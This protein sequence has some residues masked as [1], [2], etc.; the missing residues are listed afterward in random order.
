M[1]SAKLELTVGIFMLIGIL[2]LGYLSIKLGKMELIG[3]NN[4]RISARFDSVSGLKPGARIELAGVEVGT[5]ERIGLSNA[6][7]DQAEVTMK[8]KD[9][10]KIT[11]DVI[12]SVR[13][14]GIIG[15]KF[16]KLKPGGSDQLLK[17]G[18]KIRETESA[19]DIE[20]LVSKFIHG[21]VD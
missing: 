11:D 17:N 12:A 6:S 16:I 1:N 20:E 7:G 21:K 18:G 4:Y 15:D 13:T 8:I 2:C 9:G 10:I 14:S 5:V 19:I 3:S